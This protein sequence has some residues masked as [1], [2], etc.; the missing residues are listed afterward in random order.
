MSRASSIN[1]T[2]PYRTAYTKFPILCGICEKNQ[3]RSKVFSSPYQLHYHLT[4]HD[5]ADEVAAGVTR[6][7]IK[8][9]IKHLCYALELR[10]FLQ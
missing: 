5:R 2:H 8:M 9:I 3:S 6:D 4:T 1:K 10:M 7:E